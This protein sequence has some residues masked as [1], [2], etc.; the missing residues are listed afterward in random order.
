MLLTD[1]NA[2]P[3]LESGDYVY[4]PKFQKIDT[5]LNKVI[6]EVLAVQNQFNQATLLTALNA[7][8]SDLLEN[9]IIA[10]AGIVCSYNSSTGILTISAVA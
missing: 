5:S 4:V 2:N 9:R 8:V 6:D 1:K 3:F 7:I 10:G